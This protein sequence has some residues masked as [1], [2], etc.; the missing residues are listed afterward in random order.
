MSAQKT[1]ITA[2]KYVQI[3][4]DPSLVPAMK[5]S[6]WNPMEDPVQLLQC[7]VE[8]LLVKVVGVS[9]LQDGQITTHKKIS[10]V[11][12]PLHFQTPIQ[13]L[14]S[15]LM[16]QHMASMDGHLVLLIILSSLMEPR[17]MLLLSTSSVDLT[18]QVLLLLHPLEQECCLLVLLIVIAQSVV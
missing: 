10:N 2:S 6:Y 13:E 15:L 9:R 14:S 5:A 16:I 1:L 17:A 12:G 3:L 7:L 18:T 8:A 11:N 4:L